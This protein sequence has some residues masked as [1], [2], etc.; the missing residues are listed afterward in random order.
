MTLQEAGEIMDILSIAYPQ[1][2]KA[3]SDGERLKA[4]G[5][6]AAL[7]DEPAGLVAMA[8][9]AHIVSDTKGYPPHI[10][11]IKDAVIKLQTPPESE[12]SEMEAWA[13]VREAIRGASM[14]KWSR[15]LH[16]DGTV[17]KTSAERNFDALPPIVR[18]VVATPSQLAEWEGLND[19]EINTVIQSNFM[20]SYRA[21]LQDAKAMAVLPDDLRKIKGAGR[22]MLATNDEERNALVESNE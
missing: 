12:L 3:Q 4:A 18:Q 1:F 6:W 22:Y 15:I 14:E 5:L 2:Y 7:F 17:G 21:R 10:G 16:A 13:Q 9:K 8:V 11:A 20:R 19:S